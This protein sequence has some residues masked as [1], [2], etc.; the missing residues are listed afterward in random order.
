MA[1]VAYREFRRLVDLQ[2]ILTLWGERFSPR[3]AEEATGHSLAQKREPGEL[4][5]RGRYRG[6]PLPYGAAWLEVPPDVEPARRIAWLIEQAEH[7]LV[8]L[9]ELG[10]TLC[11]LHLDVRYWDQCNLTFRPQELARIAALG[12]PFTI[13]CWDRSGSPEPSTA[14]EWKLPKEEG[15]G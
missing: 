12:V 10:A 8:T 2:P 4:G 9:R 11:K 1:A 14:I 6:Q 7:H 3:R 13:T 5:V 15:P